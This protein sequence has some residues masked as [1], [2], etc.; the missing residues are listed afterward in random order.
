MNPEQLGIPLK[1]PPAIEAKL[2]A[3]I[4]KASQTLDTYNA[5]GELLPYL[6]WAG[7]VAF[8]LMGLHFARQL[9][10]DKR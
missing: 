6:V 1:L 10:G 9:L 8:V 3:A 2:E 7:V 4:V 5:A